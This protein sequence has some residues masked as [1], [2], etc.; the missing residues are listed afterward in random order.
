MAMP[1]ERVRKIYKRI[2][3]INFAMLGQTTLNRAADPGN[4]VTPQREPVANIGA[5][6]KGRFAVGGASRVPAATGRT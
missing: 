5:N 1:G 2:D 6:L 3:A 4:S